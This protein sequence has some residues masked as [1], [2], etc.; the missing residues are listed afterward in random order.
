MTE[1]C[2]SIPGDLRQDT[3]DQGTSRSEWQSLRPER[4]IMGVDHPQSV[5]KR[6]QQLTRHVEEVFDGPAGQL[7]TAAHHL[8]MRGV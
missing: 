4:A 7:S 5:I 6:A 2:Q 1:I 3:S 8:S